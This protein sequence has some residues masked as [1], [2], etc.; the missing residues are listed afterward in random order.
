MPNLNGVV[1]NLLCEIG[2]MI[3][4]KALFLKIGFEPKNLKER[5]KSLC[6]SILA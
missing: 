5:R 3:E 6:K 4:K 1:S 2:N